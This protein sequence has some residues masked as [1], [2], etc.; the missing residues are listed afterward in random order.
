MNFKKL[1]GVLKS[2]RDFFKAIDEQTLCIETQVVID[3]LEAAG[4][5]A[6][7]A[8]FKALNKEKT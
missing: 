1:I 7:Q 8:L 2:N 6:L 3:E 5:Q 4:E